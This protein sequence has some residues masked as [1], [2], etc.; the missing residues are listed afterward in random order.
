MFQGHAFVKGNDFR[1]L[2]DDPSDRRGLTAISNHEYS[3][4]ERLEGALETFNAY[5][6]TSLNDLVGRVPAPLRLPIVITSLPVYYKSQRGLG[7]EIGEAKI[8]NW[9]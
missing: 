3:T 8:Y 2:V 4:L 7:S 1:E 5:V 6:G 9:H